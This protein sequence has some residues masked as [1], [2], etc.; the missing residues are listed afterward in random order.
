MHSSTAFNSSTVYVFCG[1][2]YGTMNSIERWVVGEEKWTTIQT[3]GDTLRGKLNHKSVQVD[4]DF[5]LVFG[6]RFDKTSYKFYPKNNQVEKAEDMSEQCEM[7]SMPE[8]FYDVNTKAFYVCGK[9][10]AFEDHI[11]H[12]H[13][14]DKDNKW[15][16]VVE[17]YEEKAVSFD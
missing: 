11:S 14:F 4:N 5:I 17:N 6:G 3:S 9:D 1:R 2:S 13:K 12:I 8:P 15:S 7:E 16:V 10:F